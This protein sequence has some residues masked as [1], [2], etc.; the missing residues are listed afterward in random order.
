MPNLATSGPIAAPVV[1]S[2]S[3]IL[4]SPV[5]SIFPVG[6]KLAFRSHMKTTRVRSIAAAAR[7]STLLLPL[8]QLGGSALP[9]SMSPINLPWASLLSSNPHYPSIDVTDEQIL[10]G[11]K[12]PCQ[13]VVNHQAISGIHCRLY[14]KTDA[15]QQ[16][17]QS[18]QTSSLERVGEDE[19]DE[20]DGST[21]S[22]KPCEEEKEQV[23]EADAMIEDKNKRRSRIKVSEM[24][25][26]L[27]PAASNAADEQLVWKGTKNAT[28]TQQRL[29]SVKSAQLEIWLEDLSTNGTFIGDDVN[30]VKIGSGNKVRVRHGSEFTLLQPSAN[31]HERITYSLRINGASPVGDLDDAPTGTVTIVFTDIESSTNLWEAC[32]SGMQA[33]LEEHDRTLRTLLARFR[34]YEVKT[35]GDAFMV[36][37]FTVLDAVKWCL[38]VQE[39]LLRMKW[40]AQLLKMPSARREFVDSSSGQRTLDGPDTALLFNGLRVR[41]GLHVG[42]PSCRRNPTTKRMDYYGQMVNLAARVSDSGHGGQIVCTEEVTRI[43]IDEVQKEKEKAEREWVEEREEDGQSDDEDELDD[44]EADGC[45]RSSSDLL[46]PASIPHHRANDSITP[47]TSHHG[48]ANKAAF[49]AAF[50]EHNQAN[51]T[52]NINNILAV[53]STLGS[54]QPSQPLSPRSPRSPRSP[55]SPGT[56]NPPSLSGRPPM[57]LSRFNRIRSN[58]N[59]KPSTLDHTLDSLTDLSSVTF[60]DCGFVQLKGIKGGTKVF[61]VASLS[62]IGRKWEPPLRAKPVKPEDW[63]ETVMGEGAPAAPPLAPVTVTIYD[64]HSI[65]LQIRR[66]ILRNRRRERQESR[67][68]SIVSLAA[69]RPIVDALAATNEISAAPIVVSSSI[70]SAA[71]SKPSSKPSTPSSIKAD[72]A[73]RLVRNGVRFAESDEIH[74]VESHMEVEKQVELP[75]AEFDAKDDTIELIQPHTPLSATAAAAAAAGSEAA[76]SESNTITPATPMSYKFAQVDSTSA[77]PPSSTSTSHSTAPSTPVSASSRVSALARAFESSAPAATTFVHVAS[78]SSTAASIASTPEPAKSRPTPTRASNNVPAG[79][80]GGSVAAGT[81]AASRITSTSTPSASVSS[82]VS[83]AGQ[84]SAPSAPARTVAPLQS[85]S[86]YV[87]SVPLGDIN[88]QHS[89]SMPPTPTPKSKSIAAAHGAAARAPLAAS[90][91]L[92]RSGPQ[93]A[94]RSKHR[95]SSSSAQIVPFT[96]DTLLTSGA[97]KSVKAAM[98]KSEAERIADAMAAASCAAFDLEV[99]Q[100]RSNSSGSNV[101]GSSNNKRPAPGTSTNHPTGVNTGASSGVFNPHRLQPRHYSTLRPTS[102]GSMYN[103]AGLAHQHPTHLPYPYPPSVHLH[104]QVMTVQQQQQAHALRMLQYQQQQQAYWQQLQQQRHQHPQQQAGMIQQPFFPPAQTPSFGLS[105]SVSSAVPYSYSFPNGSQWNWQ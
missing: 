37:F 77:A 89:Q 3:A 87:E 65:P 10:I 102:S 90:A 23:S 38:A 17:Q 104:A 76:V 6:S 72:K 96:T 35:E 61:Q 100:A 18:T 71:D 21:R 53:S 105:P 74:T 101:G 86:S 5:G 46:D 47:P 59:K 7:G 64:K 56:A 55:L 69:G 11:R 84:S 4:A 49:E 26:F 32:P 43:V 92:G 42:Q 82:T 22:A 78:R 95:R 1:T 28:M 31:A 62:L 2:H 83:T 75:A 67:L 24:I 50:N 25:N 12:P 36:A 9:L 19:D 33:A 20:E 34:G 54:V 48:T 70:S 44:A 30:A 99:R 60:D 68:G 103:T 79:K 88:V 14:K 51:S 66:N 93:T 40:D 57:D 63:A 39:A 8:E 16:Q 29:D 80:A 27:G 13:L 15:Q 45:G 91:A 58:V 73:R 81:A 41:M 97:A 85:A 94:T 98:A 52:A